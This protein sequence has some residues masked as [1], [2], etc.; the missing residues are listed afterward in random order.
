MQEQHIKLHVILSHR[1]RPTSAME[2]HRLQR[3][4][5]RH[6]QL[7]KAQRLGLPGALTW[8]LWQSRVTVVDPSS[9]WLMAR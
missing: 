4:S 7:G 8:R 9:P 6:Y 3:G 2:T 1:R 5:N